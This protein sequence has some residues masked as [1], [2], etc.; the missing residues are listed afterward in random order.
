MGMFLID[1]NCKKQR[2]YV[3]IPNFHNKGYLGEGL[4]ILHDDLEENSS[5]SECCVDIIQ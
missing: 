4:V 5:H 3:G 1:T 2:E